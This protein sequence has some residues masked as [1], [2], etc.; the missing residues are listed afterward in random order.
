MG[1]EIK[2]VPD[3]AALNRVAA[4]EF[5][6]A[7]NSAIAE[8]GWFSVA[9]SG[10]HTPRTVYELLSVEYKTALSWEKV[11]IFF[12][13]ERDVPPD[14]PDSNYRM[15]NEAL[16][17]KVPIPAG[18]IH[19]IR[20]EL[21]PEAAAKDYEEQIHAQFGLK[22]N[23]L[24]RFDL[25]LLGLGPDGHTASLFPGTAALKETSRL[26]VLNWVEKLN[27]FR[28]TLTF[29][30]LNHAAEDLFLVS[31]PDKAQILKAVLGPQSTVG[32]PA[33]RVRPES[34]RLLWLFDQDAAKLL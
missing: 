5:A 32:Y 17:S 6:S 9:L 8:H 25:I 20:T 4:A 26:V 27:T 33:Q 11:H 3:A 29:P 19:R 23:G 10:G 14:H 31:G 7:A 28:I 24:P 2:I 1:T 16:L 13:D 21:D 15:A 30:V 12:G 22:N 34:G 18:N